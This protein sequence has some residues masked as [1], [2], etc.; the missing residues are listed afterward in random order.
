M[1]DYSHT[2][3]KK[4]L[5]YIDSFASFCNDKFSIKNAEQIQTQTRITEQIIIFFENLKNVGQQAAQE[6]NKPTDISK[7]LICLELSKLISF[8]VIVRV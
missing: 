3:T 6:F 1:K 8:N 5:R 7:R 2:F 4:L